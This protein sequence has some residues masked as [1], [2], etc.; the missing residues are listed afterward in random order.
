M[1]LLG[2]G[3]ITRAALPRISNTASPRSEVPSA[4]KR[5]TPSMPAKPEGFDQRLRGEAPGT[6]RL[7]QRGDERNR[8]IGKARG[9][10]RIAPEA[11]L[12]ALG[13][14]LI[15]G[16][17]GRGE[18]GAG[19]IGIGEQLGVVPQA[20]ADELHAAGFDPVLREQLQDLRRG[21]GGIG[22]EKRIGPAQRGGDALDLFGELRL[23]GR[24]AL[25]RHHA[26]ALVSAT[27]S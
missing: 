7:D 23:F 18:P 9:A 17:L 6:L 10:H 13:K 16:G 15:A 24:I 1:K 11:R 12:V 27:V 4:L 14:G 26:A 5:K 25:E 22:D 21:V 3:L 2:E 8:V 19:Q 20:G